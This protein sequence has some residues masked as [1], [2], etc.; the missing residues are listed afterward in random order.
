LVTISISSSTIRFNE[1]VN[2]FL[3]SF[4]S[5]DFI[6]RRALELFLPM[7]HPTQ[8][9]KVHVPSASNIDGHKE[10]FAIKR[11]HMTFAQ[12]EKERA[13]RILQLALLGGGDIV[14]LES[15][16]CDLAT[17]INTARCTSPCDLF[18]ILQHNFLRLQKRHGTQ[19]LGERLRE[20]VVLSL[21]AY[22]SRIMQ[23]PLFTA[24]MKKQ[25][26]PP[27]NE[28]QQQYHSKPSWLVRMNNA[29]YSV[30]VYILFLA[31][32]LNKLFSIHVGQVQ[33]QHV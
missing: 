8:P 19:G 14:G 27:V 32:L 15:Y 2:L 22:P 7:L 29:P 1:T 31:L 21:Q 33:Q 11:R 4:Y 5:I 17:Y 10:S 3:I 20:M 30:C 9:S 23:L 12:A 6:N 25:L 28:E 24:L 18:Y 13:Q 16:V 26:A